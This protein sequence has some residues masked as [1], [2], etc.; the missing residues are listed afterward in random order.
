MQ[1]TSSLGPL[2]P[3]FYQEP[4][5]ESGGPSS[6]VSFSP[7]IEPSC[8]APSLSP[9]GPQ[10]W[11]QKPIRST[12]EEKLLKKRLIN[13]LGQEKDLLGET[14]A[15]LHAE[16]S[17]YTAKER[18]KLAKLV[19]SLKLPWFIVTEEQRK[20]I[21][22]QGINVASYPRL[23]PFHSLLATIADTIAS[24]ITSSFKDKLKILETYYTNFIAQLLEASSLREREALLALKVQVC[25]DSVGF[26]LLDINKALAMLSMDDLGLPCRTNTHGRHAVASLG[27]LHCKGNPKAAIVSDYLKPAWEYAATSL[28][29][30]FSLKSLI[31]AP[32]SFLKISSIRIFNWHASPDEEAKQIFNEQLWRGKTS[33]QIFKEYPQLKK[34]LCKATGFE[35]YTMQVGYTIG[36][37]VENERPPAILLVDLISILEIFDLLCD[38][39]L[40]TVGE[41][42]ESWPYLLEEVHKPYSSAPEKLFHAYKMWMEQLPEELRLKEF[43][44]IG[45]F[46]LKSDEQGLDLFRKDFLENKEEDNFWQLLAILKLHPRLAANASLASLIELPLALRWIVKLFP[47]KS[48]EELFRHIPLL[49]QKIDKEAFSSLILASLLILP[50]DGKADNYIVEL[51][52][53]DQELESLKLV[54]ID[55]DQA[56]EPAI[57]PA[58]KGH[59]IHLKCLPLLLKGC[60]DQS[61]APSLK[62]FLKNLNPLDF[63]LGWIK[64][65]D[66]RNQQ[67]KKLIFQKQLTNEDFLDETAEKKLDIPLLLPKGLLTIFFKKLQLVQDKLKQDLVTHHDLFKVLEPTAFACYQALMH[68]HANPLDA[69]LSLHHQSTTVEALVGTSP[70]SSSNALPC[71]ISFE[72]EVSAFLSSLDWFAGI[73]TQLTPLKAIANLSFCPPLSLS[74]AQKQNLLFIAI[75]LG[76]ASL[77][78]LALQLGAEINQADEAGQTAL[79]K[80]MRIYHLPNLEEEQIFLIA[81]LLLA[82][83][84]LD[85]NALDEQSSPPIFPLINRASYASSRFSVLLAKL[86]KRGADLDYPD[87]LRQGETPLEKA[88][89][90]DNLSLFIELAKNGAGAKAHPSKIL[91]F[92]NK[93][94]HYPHLVQA[95]SCLEAQL[96]AFAYLRSLAVFTTKAT[97]QGFEWEGVDSGKA[98]LHP[99]V[100][101]QLPLDAGL[102]FYKLPRTY[103]RSAVVAVSYLHRKLHFKPYPEMA[104]MEYAVG[105]LHRLIIGHGVPEA[106]LFK[107]YNMRRNPYPLLVSETSEGKNLEDV[108]KA[109]STLTHLD[110]HRVHNMM[111]LAMLVNPEDGKP[112]NYILQSFTN[113]QGEKKDQ[114]VSID[115]DHA[116]LPSFSKDGK[117]KVKCILFCLNQMYTALHPETRKL[118]LKIKPLEIL[119]TWLKNLDEQQQRY[120][121][122]FNEKERDYVYAYNKQK[123]VISILLPPKTIVR[124]YQKL[125]C[126]QRAIESNAV[127]TPLELLFRL[128]PSLGKYYAHLLQDIA[129][130]PYERFLKG[131]GHFY[132][133]AQQC[134]V[135]SSTTSSLLKSSNIPAKDLARHEKRYLPQEALKELQMLISQSNSRHLQAVA[136]AIKKGN[137]EPFQDLLTDSLREA[138]LAFLKISKQKQELALLKAM[139]A[140]SFSSLS[141]KNCKSLDGSLLKRLLEASKVLTKLDASHCDTLKS[142]SFV[143]LPCLT[144]LDLS[145]CKRLSKLALKAPNLRFLALK[146]NA[147]LTSLQLEA[148]SLEELDLEGCVNLPTHQVASL[149][150]TYPGLKSLALPHRDPSLLM[151]YNLPPSSLAITLQVRALFENT[152]RTLQITQDLLSEEECKALKEGLRLN[153]SLQE[154]DLSGF[155]I[156]YPFAMAL[157]Q[158][159]ENNQRLNRLSFWGNEINYSAA[160]PLAKAL[161]DTSSI[162]HLRLYDIPLDSQSIMAFAEGIRNNSSLAIIELSDNQINEE[163]A[164]VF[165]K[166]LERNFSLTELNF[167]NNQLADRGAIAIAKSLKS[168]ASITKLVLEN[169]RIKDEGALAL[170][171]ALKYNSSLVELILKVNLIGNKGATA[172]I[173]LVE[174]N[175]SLTQLD[176]SHNLVE[177]AE[178]IKSLTSLLLRNKENR[179]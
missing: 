171:K 130:S 46:S 76:R 178:I 43:S 133:K 120:E 84:K 70:L 129:A 96:P 158:V 125:T 168:K 19:P 35:S 103:G 92:V 95:L 163:G 79:H 98:Q 165:A 74:L 107:C 89:A 131:P 37:S 154:V 25:G 14:I 2:Q 175:R 111:L 54:C 106:E 155:P 137:I 65:L 121:R 146:N 67:Y 161:K 1:I 13:Y 157:A 167:S 71:L 22:E 116:F 61:V 145:N 47:E 45:D 21:I 33:F 68:K 105:R 30:A 147:A 81:E 119:Q 114:L 139:A 138:A 78:K 128:D 93:H 140:S 24:I 162:T 69:L 5:L 4:A 83:E 40:L 176:I 18:N 50:N 117:L 144:S 20:E 82:H 91:K 124:I 100:V 113:H 174:S 122:L 156:A 85:P 15:H 90:E 36:H 3:V 101:Q 135:T 141:L 86:V 102:E 11:P 127:L 9:R 109:G 7:F 34:R 38:E 52:W 123:P 99:Q 29:Q 132:D 151:R 42:I 44:C 112:D 63:L 16:S 12:Q 31:A 134:L 51:F 148:P 64:L 6:D 152:L 179:I 26:L 49:L 108:L 142:F 27:G 56:F 166:S 48:I 126:M 32:T 164:S 172:L 75:D 77:V 59:G 159:I 39:R 150:E 88:M 57:I 118:F 94:A 66:Q 17:L 97:G 143:E 136:A 170:S 110:L 73:P 72:E 28:T 115:N 55:N 62:E 104:G 60:M 153:S 173:N 169:N 10:I 53:K 160:T 87:L 58:E 149:L 80:L 23:Q 8:T 41:L 177:D